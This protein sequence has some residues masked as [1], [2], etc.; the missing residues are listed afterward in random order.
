MNSGC[1]YTSS[2]KILDF[3]ISL[4]NAKSILN[5]ILSK[6]GKPAV[7]FNIDV[8][9]NAQPFIFRATAEVV[10]LSGN[11]YFGQG[12][13]KSKRL[14]TAECAYNILEEISNNNEYQSTDKK[15]L[16]K[17]GNIPQ[18]LVRVTEDEALYKDVKALYNWLEIELPDFPVVKNELPEPEYKKI[19]PPTFFDFEGVFRETNRQSPDFRNSRKNYMNIWSPPIPNYDC[20]KNSMVD[21]VLFK[22]KPLDK[23]SQILLSIENR[24]TP[25]MKIEESRKHLPIYDKKNDI[26]QA[27]EESQILLIKSSTGSGKSTQIGQFLLKHYIDNMKG[28]EF[29]CIIT[30]PR[31]LAAINLAKRVAEE[32]YECVGESIGYCVRFEKLYPRPF[33]SILYATVGTIIKKLSN[34]LKGISHIIVDEVHER[35]LETDF[36]LII[37]KKMLSNCSG[38][39]IILMSATIDTTQFEKYM[40]GIRVMELHGKS[41]EVMELYLDE[42]I[43]HYKIYPSLFVPPPGYDVNSN[44]WDFNYL[45]NGKLISP[46]G[47]YITEQI[48][49]SD[50]IPYDIIKMMVE[51]SCKAMISS[52]EQGSILI[53]LPGWSEI[54]LCMEELKT[55]ASEDMYWL[56]PLHSNLSFDDQKKVFKSP[57]KDKFK[58][59][60]ST[61]IAESS[62]TVDDV[63]YVIDSC[64]QKKQLINHKSATC[65]YEVSYTSKDCMDQRKGRAGRIRKGYCFRLISRSLWHTL[66]LHTEAEIKTAP[67]DSTILGI[68]ALGLGDSVSFLKDSIEQIDERNIIEAEEYLRQLSA[69]DKNKNITYIGRVMERLPFTPETAKCVLTATLF[70]VAD[71]IAFICGYYNS[72]LPLFNNPFKQLEIA[73]AILQLCGDFISDHIL[74]LLALKINT[75]EYKNVNYSLPI[76][77]LINKDNMANLYMVK[78]QIFE[79][80]KNEFQNTDFH[81][82]GVS[83]NKDSSAQMHVIMSLLVKSFYPNIAIQSKKRVFIDMEGYKVALNKISVLCLDKNNYEDR[84]PFIIYSQKIITK[85]TMFKECSVISP[86]QL[87]LFGYKEVIYKGGNKLIIDDVIIFDIDPKFGQMIIYL[88]IIIDSLLQSL[89]ARGFLSE[90]EQAIK[91]YIRNLVERVSTMGYT[92]NGRTFPKKDLIGVTKVNFQEIGG[93]TN[94]M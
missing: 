17:K 91:H 79:V 35:S 82:Y 31:R 70:N 24:K 30:Q 77:K 3:D 12:M 34:G 65:Y 18:L 89:C 1:Q 68:K 32:R 2:F 52:N 19:S 74:P 16:P 63:L 51:E 7:C 71:S 73:D 8:M 84:S 45:P 23:I 56:V 40:N 33:G 61:N 48:E 93:M 9:N 29:N 83:S 39:K 87:L 81:E 43:Q 57:P 44:L 15:N 4:D 27:V 88:K 47:T 41:Y 21:D 42:F 6:E 20:W 25:L 92:I 90:K 69:L 62:I 75:A 26:I 59:I 28:A 58:I 22:E 36:L 13:G 94:W 64:R 60:V 76:L 86:L 50:E 54:I 11:I 37:L 38:I 49:S 78:N 66:P 46:L 80:L 53:F 14:A 72:N 67:L 10:L 5:Q 55:S 85:Y